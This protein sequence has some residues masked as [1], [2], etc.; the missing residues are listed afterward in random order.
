[1]EKESKGRGK[2][3]REK[4]KDEI[5]A[6][7]EEKG[8]GE[9]GKQSEGKEEGK[10]EDKEGVEKVEEFK[11]REMEGSKWY[12]IF[13]FFFFFFFCTEIRQIAPAQKKIVLVQESIK[14]KSWKGNNA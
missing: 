11:G 12:T 14:I 8:Q 4:L 2:G 13:F 7:K 9:E 3:R 6:C 5:G 1:M 10:L